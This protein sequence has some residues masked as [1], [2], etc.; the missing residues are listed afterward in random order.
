MGGNDLR[1][2]RVR[3]LC[4]TC[5][6]GSAAG[7]VLKDAVGKQVGKTLVEQAIKRLPYKTIKKTN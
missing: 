1:D 2:D 3:T 6:S 7:D 5:L 4:Y